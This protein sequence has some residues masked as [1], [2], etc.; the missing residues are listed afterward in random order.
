[1][2]G[3]RRRHP[4]ADRWALATNQRGGQLG[5]QRKTYREGITVW[6]KKRGKRIPSLYKT[7]TVDSAEFSPRSILWSGLQRP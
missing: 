4:V 7:V 2:V 6:K 3:N 1:M 5:L